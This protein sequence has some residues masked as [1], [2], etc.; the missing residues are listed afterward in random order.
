MGV[1]ERG[2]VG[3]MEGQR[4]NISIRETRQVWSSKREFCERNR[5]WGLM[6]YWMVSLISWGWGK[7]TDSHPRDEGIK[8]FSLETTQSSAVVCKPGKFYSWVIFH[9][10]WENFKEASCKGRI[11]KR[12]N[13]TVCQRRSGMCL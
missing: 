12:L 3:G 4:M 2:T 10:S 8:L 9:P 13:Q 1:R 7:L 11:W 6:L 5:V